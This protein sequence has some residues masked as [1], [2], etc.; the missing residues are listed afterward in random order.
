MWRLLMILIFP[1]VSL[2][3]CNVVEIV[4]QKNEKKLKKNAIQEAYF[5]EGTTK[6]HYWKGGKGPTLLLIHGFAQDAGVD[7]QKEMLYFSKNYTVIAADLIWFGKSYSTESANLQTQTKVII[8]LLKSLKIDTLSIIGQ[9]YGGFLAVDLAMSKSFKID[10]LLI[11]NSPGP[12]FD[13]NELQSVCKKYNVQKVNDILIPKSPD[14]IQTIN[15]MA[16]YQDKKIPKIFRKQYFDYYSGQNIEQRQALL[17]SLPTEKERIADM[18]VLKNIKT[19]VLWGKEDELFP[20]KEGEKF[21]KAINAT[22]ISIPK[23]GHAMQI[24]DHV[25]FIKTLDDFLSGKIN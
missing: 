21:A 19:L 5:E 10:K 18:E 9:S 2:V 22:F 7:W 12:T 20:E 6:L 3:S 1:F 13:V 24:D 11:A 23:T 4:H 17:N 25:I 16:V 14:D 15:N 8:S